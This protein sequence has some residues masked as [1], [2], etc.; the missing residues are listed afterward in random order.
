MAPAL[1]KFSG[2]F[3]ERFFDVGIA[4]GMPYLCR[5]LAP[6][7]SGRYR[8]LSTFVQRAYDQFFHDFCLQKLP[9]DHCMD[10]AVL[11]GDDGPPHHGVMDYSYCVTCLGYHHD[12]PKDE[13]ELRHM[14]NNSPTIRIPH[15]RRVIPRAMVTVWNW[16]VSSS[17]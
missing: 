2:T 1:K 8:H 4:S 9:S 15:N 16:T 3:P 6:M 17:H 10:R 5:R 14:L 11:V 12:G 13:N 7:D